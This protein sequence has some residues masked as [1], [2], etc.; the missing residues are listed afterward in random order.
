MLLPDPWVIQP[1]N[2]RLDAK[3]GP[4]GDESFRCRLPAMLIGVPPESAP[5]ERR[6]S[7]TP[8]AV[9]RLTD[10]HYEVAVAKGAGEGAFFGDQDY[11]TAGARVVPEEDAWS[12]DLICVVNRPSEAQ[13]SYLSSQNTLLGLLEPLDEPESVRQLT[14]TG[15]TL[16][17][18]ELLPRTTRAQ[19][20]D[21]LSS[22]ATAAGY[23]AVIVAAEYSPRFFPMLTTAAGTVPPA[24]VLV[25][26]AGVA[27]LQAIATARRLGGR[28]SGYDVREAAREQ[29]ESLGASFVSLAVEAQDASESGGYARALDQD[30][31]ERQ[32]AQLAPHVAGSDV[33]ITTAAVPG[34]RAPL[35]VTGEMVQAMAAGSVV[36]DLSAAT[37]GNCELTKPGE[38]VSFSDV[39]ILGPI[40]L[41]S[42]V[43]AHSSQLYARN[44][45]EMIT[46]ISTPTALSIDID[47]EIVAG[48]LVAQNGEVVHP[49][50]LAALEEGR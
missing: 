13:E 4:K 22:Q 9:Q 15:A 28:V 5:A 1:T 33:V 31:Q 36:V 47:D 50:V 21:A 24:R 35:L 25:L 17:S 12:A 26:G 45:A 27:G 6:V 42:R 14:Q 8:N 44:V 34:K 40:D 48:C 16:L 19:P 43:P 39:T 7:L 38:A 32:L 46:Y 29:V 49:A 18:F 37:G 3:K 23:Q 10:S 30:D 41:P 11:T 2:V 20:M